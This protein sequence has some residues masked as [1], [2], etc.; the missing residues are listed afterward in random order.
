MKE[1]EG[2]LVDGV[3]DV[4]RVVCPNRSGLTATGR[5]VEIAEAQGEDSECGC[6]DII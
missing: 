6:L 3:A 4:E 1:G 5:G 2:K